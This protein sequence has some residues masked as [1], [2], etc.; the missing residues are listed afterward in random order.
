MSKKR[1]AGCPWPLPVV[2]RH[3]LISESER[4]PVNCMRQQAP[5][6]AFITAA[7]RV[8]FEGQAYNNGQLPKRRCRLCAS[9]GAPCHV[10]VRMCI[11]IDFLVLP[12]ACVVWVLNKFEHQDIHHPISMNRAAA[13]GDAHQT[14]IFLSK[15]RGK[16][17]DLQPS[18]SGHVPA[19]SASYEML[20]Q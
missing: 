8:S 5:L 14:G 12:T 19:V 9:L 17:T 3:R 1:G 16:S 11:C 2:T 20:L 7:C 13:E 4:R 6:F 10:C 18:W 15:V